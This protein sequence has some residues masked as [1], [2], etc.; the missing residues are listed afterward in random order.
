MNDNKPLHTIIFHWIGF[1]VILTTG[2]LEYF[3]PHAVFLSGGYVLGVL[4]TIFSKHNRYIFFSMGLS[5]SLIAFALIQTRNKS[6]FEIQLIPQAYTCLGLVITALFGLQIVNREIRSANSKSLMAGIF[7]YGTQG[8]ILTN[9]RGDIILVNPFSEK[10][11][12]YNKEELYEVR[13]ASLISEIMPDEQVVLYNDQ[14]NQFRKDLSAIR[15]DG[16]IFSVEVSLNKYKSGK[17]SYIVAFITDIT[18]RKENEETLIQ[19]KQELENVNKELEAFSYSVS[20]DLRAP[21]R[22]VSGYAR[23]LEDDHGDALN[24]DAKRLLLIIQESAKNMG[25]LIDDLLSFSRL[26][27]KEIRKSLVNMT[28]LANV[29]LCEIN[30]I[31]KHHAEVIIN[32]LHATLADPSLIMLVLTNILSN[33]LKYSSKVEKPIVI[34]TSY[35]EKDTVTYSIKD[36]GA[37]FDMRYIQKLFGVFQRLHTSDEFEGTGVGLAIAQRIIHKHGGKIWAEGKEGMGSTFY[38]SLP[39]MQPQQTREGAEGHYPLAIVR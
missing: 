26:G 29:T 25:I 11:F 2:V 19:R 8:I 23:M 33:A 39:R 22:A 21:L 9:E 38:F 14:P 37:G 17:A 4:L 15:K 24:D 30:L 31:T 34:I 1:G 3:S 5:F 12:G 6:D 28:E 32:P 7:S 36:N 27:K 18:T 10:M 16:S 20:H 35:E 13:I